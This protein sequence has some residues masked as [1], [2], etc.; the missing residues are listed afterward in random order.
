M[1][2]INTVPLGQSGTGAAFVLPQSRAA[3]QLQETLEYNQRINQQQQLLKQQQ[4]QQ[5][6]Q[7]WKTN[8]LKVDGG[9]YWQPEFNKKYQ[10]H[11]QK[12]IQLRQ[13]GVDPFNYNPSDPTQSK[14][15]ENYLLERQ[16]IM[17]DTQ[18][19]KV[20]ETAL[21]P[22]FDKIRQNP[23]GFY[24][25]D[26]Q[27][28]N[29]YINKPFSEASQMQFPTL[30]DR[31]N[32]NSVLSKVTPAQ[33]GSEVVVGNQRI[34]S[35]KALPQETRKAIVG[36]Y[37]ND[38]ASERW[39]NEMTGN[40][41]FTIDELEK[42]PKGL[43]SIK[44]EIERNYKGNPQ[45]RTTLASQGITPNSDAYKQYVDQQ[46]QR[47]Y[48]AKTAWDNQVE[49]DVQQV[50]PQVKAMSSTLPD[51]T[52]ENQEFKRQA[53]AR[54][55]ARFS[56]WESNKKEAGTY[57]QFLE[58]VVTL[59]PNAINELKTVVEE[60]GAK[61]KRVY[62]DVITID[63]KKKRIKNA[64]VI[65]VPVE[66]EVRVKDTEGKDVINSDGSYKTKKSTVNKR[67][68]MGSTIGG[69][70]SKIALNQILQKA[71]S[72]GALKQNKVTP[73]VE[74]ETTIEGWED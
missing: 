69:R 7:S 60:V 74:E 31:F 68:L 17:Q 21:K 65:D 14:I 20:N 19:R 30:T 29:D 50:L 48:T 5:L 43:D 6:A 53:N 67:Y 64:L 62:D 66:T 36:A 12:G 24:A 44:S 37:K 25:S 8:Q 3:Q 2:E 11:L 61:V 28:A 27:Y 63:G 72:F 9:L 41:G 49:S 13:M 38:P 45:L 4:A 42:I 73:Y 71:K 10:D 34:K 23:S 26:I 32:P 18:N 35:V 39:V 47:L 15:A 33:I 16:Q 51:Y 59:K 70:Q 58:D 22:V 55:N 46:A 40:V 57:D 52:A 1:A 56:D 54:A